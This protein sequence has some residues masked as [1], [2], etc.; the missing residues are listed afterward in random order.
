MYKTN[1]V[2]VC[3]WLPDRCESTPSVLR[4]KERL[5]WSIIIK[6]QKRQKKTKGDFFNHSL[7]VV[8]VIVCYSTPTF[9]RSLPIIIVTFHLSFFLCFISYSTHYSLSL[10]IMMKSYVLLLLATTTVLFV[11]VTVTVTATAL[12]KQFLLD[13]GQVWSPQAGKPKLPFGFCPME[14]RLL[15]QAM[16]VA[17]K[18]TPQ[19][20]A[21]LNIDTDYSFIAKGST[22]E[23]YGSSFFT[24]SD[25]GVDF[26]TDKNSVLVI[27]ESISSGTTANKIKKMPS[28]NKGKK[29]LN[30]S[31]SHSESLCSVGISVPRYE[32]AQYSAEKMTE[33]NARRQQANQI[34][35]DI[36]APLVKALYNSKSTPFAQP[37]ASENPSP[38]V[39]VGKWTHTGTAVFVR[40]AT[41]VQEPAFV[42]GT[43]GKF[44]VA[45]SYWWD[46]TPETLTAAGKATLKA[47]RD[48]DSTRSTCSEPD[49][50]PGSEDDDCKAFWTGRK[51]RCRV[52]E[53][54]YFN[55]SAGRAVAPTRVENKKQDPQKPKVEQMMMQEAGGPQAGTSQNGQKAQKAQKAQKGKKGK[56]SKK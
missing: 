18:A 55:S 23:T 32:T 20:Y 25:F 43:E 19:Q 52:A 41:A 46:I 15:K 35:K 11:A 50:M 12:P 54:H 22:E 53:I 37:T 49:Q 8:R 16:S 42:S 56:K 14:T 13:D 45:N 44:F 28:K 40:A 3:V 39:A 47:A 38:Q 29:T 51:Y 33:V 24:T 4:W 48:A 21:M 17:K 31:G 10:A 27:S 26:N 34:S 2:L 36:C 9:S 5:S 7:E 30:P 1:A 6:K